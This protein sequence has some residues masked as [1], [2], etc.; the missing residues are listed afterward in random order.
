MKCGKN[1]ESK[2]PKVA[3]TKNRRICFYQNVKS[4]IVKKLKFIKQQEA[5]KL[6]WNLTGIKVPILNDLQ[7]ANILFSKYKINAI[8]NKI[9]LPGDKFMPEMYLRQP[10]F[11]CSACGPFTKNKERMKKLKKQE[12][13]DVFIKTN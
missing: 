8:V 10:G 9:L 6:L 1:T 5:R 4:V 7:I 12:I 3:R 13:Q 2:Y 11:T